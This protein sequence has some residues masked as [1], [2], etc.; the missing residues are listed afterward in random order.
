M[1]HGPC[2]FERK[3]GDFLFVVPSRPAFFFLL[4]FCLFSI[5]SIAA[6]EAPPTITAVDEIGRTVKLP[7]RPVR[8]ISLAPSVTETLFMLKADDRLIGVTSQCTWPEAAKK[9]PIIAELL[10]PNYEVILKAKPDLILA[11]TA[12]N[13]RESVLKL[14][15]LGLPVFV[16]AP[17]SVQSILES[18][19]DI[20]RIIDASEAA[21]SLVAEMKRRLADLDLKLR[22]VAPVTVFFITWF[23][24]LLAPGRNTFE[25]DLLRLVKATSISGALTDFYPRYSLEQ[26]LARDPDAIITVEHTGK[27]LP[28]LSKLPGWSYLRAVRENKVFVLNEAF[29]HPSPRFLTAL[30]ELARK[31][32]PERFR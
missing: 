13:D 8:I 4:L 7:K 2:L 27:P 3:A 5:P 9:K 16:T 30:E 11:S 10:N 18:V 26:V 21:E 31:L 29:Q 15:G 1:P 25:N 32:Y 28:N 23:E 6:P 22:G 17:R 20:G 19:S 12:G 14:A 24:P